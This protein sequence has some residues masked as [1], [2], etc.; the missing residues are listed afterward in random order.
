MSLRIIIFIFFSKY[1]FLKNTII[2]EPEK[3]NQ[4]A[5]TSP[6]FKQLSPEGIIVTKCIQWMR[7]LM[8]IRRNFLVS[9]SRQ[10]LG[11]PPQFQVKWP[12]RRVMNS[13]SS[14]SCAWSKSIYLIFTITEFKHGSL[15]FFNSPFLPCVSILITDR[16]YFIAWNIKNISHSVAIKCLKNL[17]MAT[18]I[19]FY[20]PSSTACN[21]YYSGRANW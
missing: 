9:R 14:F 2:V 11:G 3:K 17:L 8:I 16:S 6:T 10:L 13:S 15:R 20:L 21:L 7:P 5:L 19:V 18:T 4:L 12:G 1:I